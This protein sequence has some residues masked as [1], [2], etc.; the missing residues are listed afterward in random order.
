MRFC[1]NSTRSY[2]LAVLTDNSGL[3][4]SFAAANMKTAPTQLIVSDLYVLGYSIQPQNAVFGAALEMYT[5]HITAGG[6]VH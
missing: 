6:S 1:Y 2:C 3:L 4:P 5:E